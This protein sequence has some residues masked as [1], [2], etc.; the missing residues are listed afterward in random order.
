MEWEKRFHPLDYAILTYLIILS[1]LIVIFHNNLAHWQR[2]LGIHIVVIRVIIGIIRAESYFSGGV[3]TFLRTFY[4]LL[5]YGFA[6]KELDSL[7]NLIFPF[8]GTEIIIKGDM[9]LFGAHPIIM[10]EKIFTP[11]LTETMN[12]FYL[13]YFLFIPVPALWLYFSSRR[14][15]TLDFLFCVYF[16]Y[17]SVYLFSIFFPVE[18]AWIALKDLYTMEPKGGLFLHLT[19]LVQQNGSVRGGAFP[20]V[21][22]T[23][24][25]AAALATFRYNRKMGWVMIFLSPGI[26]LSTVYCRYHHGLDALGGIIWGLTAYLVSKRLLKKWINSRRID[27]QA[28]TVPA[29]FPVTK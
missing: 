17:L 22:V 6:W 3:L 25:V 29:A 11:W 24:C 7:F 12:F 13:I 23:G 10:V 21:H 20:S 1:I 8:Y 2:Y 15:E 28:A 16:A 9:L 4:P 5:G 19:Q 14:G 18:G 26:I 27:C